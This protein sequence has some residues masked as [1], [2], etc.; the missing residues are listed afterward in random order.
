M[1]V[2]VMPVPDTKA[3]PGLLVALSNEQNGYGQ[4]PGVCQREFIRLAGFPR[5]TR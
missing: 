3:G 4:E 5:I 2:A 1:M